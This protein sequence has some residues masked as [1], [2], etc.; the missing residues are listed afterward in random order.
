LIIGD[1]NAD[2][3]TCNGQKTVN[4]CSMQ[5][6]QYLINE[7]TIITPKIAVVLDQ[8]LSGSPAF[9]DQVNVCQPVATSDHCSISVK[10]KFEIVNELPY[11]HFI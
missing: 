2:F 1:L 8:I 6:L 3:K 11:E 5:N 9:I 4:M 7:P 10:V